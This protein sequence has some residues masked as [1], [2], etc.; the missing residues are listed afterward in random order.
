MTATKPCPHKKWERGDL[1]GDYRCKRCGEPKH[2]ERAFTYRLSP[3]VSLTAGQA[4]RVKRA[5]GEV[6]TDLTLDAFRGTFRWA[7]GDLLWITEDQAVRITSVENGRKVERLHL[8]TAAWRP[9]R[10]HRV[11]VDHKTAKR[12]EDTV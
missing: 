8:Q 7:E 10:A 3:R 12:R 2:P 5:Q 9:V 4:V 11:V 1:A 6:F